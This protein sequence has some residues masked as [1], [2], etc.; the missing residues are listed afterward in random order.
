VPNIFSSRKFTLV[1][2]RRRGGDTYQRRYVTSQL[3]KFPVKDDVLLC[4][5]VTHAKDNREG[6]GEGEGERERER[7]RRQEEGGA[8]TIITYRFPVRN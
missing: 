4:H 1:R 7:E 5:G 6:E 8:E 3:E 2:R